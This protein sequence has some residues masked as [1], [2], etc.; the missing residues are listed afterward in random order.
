[1]KDS[2]TSKFYTHEK[3]GNVPI[4][5]DVVKLGDYFDFFPTASYARAL[6][7]ENG[8]CGYIHY[9]DIHTRFDRFVDANTD[10]LPCISYEMAKKYTSLTDGDLIISDA[11]EDYEGVGKSIEVTNVGDKFIISGLHTLHLRVKKD[12]SKEFVVG[13]KGYVLNQEKVRNNILRIA[14]GIKVYSISKTELKKVYLPKPPKEE[15]TAIAAILSKVDEAIFAT[16]NTIKAAEKLKKALMQNLLTGKLKPDG[17]RRTDDEFYLDEKFGKVPLGW[18]IKEVK[19]CFDFYPSA[20]YSRSKLIESGETMYIHYGDIHTKFNRVLDVDNQTIPFIPEDLRKNFELLKDGDLIVSDASED[21]VGVGKCIEI[22]NIR[23]RRIIAGL[24]TIH[25]RP[26]S[27]DFI[28]GIKGYIFNIYKVALNIKRLA[29]GIKVYGISKPNIG[30]VLLPI[31]TT[32]EQE[33]IKERLD[34]FSY[35]IEYKTTK[36]QTLQRLKKSLMQNL[37]TG[38][39]R[40]DVAMINE[41]LKE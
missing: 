17:S 23:E 38:K 1:M 2:S 25:L 33:K 37:L 32:S 18:K 4:G 28:L 29:T 35:D 3:F 11:S 41:L 14:T 5:W 16:Q 26:K 21:W 7:S 20:S 24:H 10:T 19:E 40:V 12:K 22:L 30:K 8:D 39:I 27:E 34:F 36:I 13:F 6:L 31:P 9:G 15:Q